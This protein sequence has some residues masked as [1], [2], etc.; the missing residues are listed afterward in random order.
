MENLGIFWNKDKD[1]YSSK[2]ISI[3]QNSKGHYYCSNYTRKPY[4]RS[5][6]FKIN[7]GVEIFKQIAPV[8]FTEW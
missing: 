7:E 1:K 4:A 5:R 2:V 8:E 6:P 3:C